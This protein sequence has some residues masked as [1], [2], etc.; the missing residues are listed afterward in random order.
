[1]IR[2]V[3][4]YLETREIESQVSEILA[5]G[6]LTRGPWVD[7]LSRRLESMTGALRAFPTSSATT[8]LYASLRALKIGRGDE[9]LVAD[10]SFPATAN[11]VEECGARPVFVDV[12]PDRWTLDASLLDGLRTERTRAVI[13]VDALGNPSGLASTLE[14]CR[15][16]GLPLIED[17]ACSIGSRVDGRLVGALADLTCFSFHPRKL[18]TSGEGGAILTCDPGLA[19][20]LEVKLAHGGVPSA[21]RFEFIDHG[22][23]FRLP[24]IQCAMLMPQLD[25][26]D[27][28]VER[29][30]RF[31]RE[32]AEGLLPLGFSPQKV[33]PGIIHNVQSL[34]FRVP[35]GS[36]RD[37]LIR[38]LR[39]HGMESTIGTYSMSGTTYFRNRY[40]NPLP[41]SGMLE[42]ETL[43]LPCHDA[44]E[45]AQVVSRVRRAFQEQA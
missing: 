15:R 30:R 16:H 32:V 7:A 10:F 29:R 2:L 11:V 20:T 14:W 45:A 8:A 13:F 41:V 4:P 38:R 35:A 34:A 18:L 22:F 19:E 24:E 42:R 17:A 6:I 44:V 1:M 37:E 40:G 3:R 23:N 31:A 25:Q 33:D 5:T 43:T 9:V 12:D 27:R 21:G 39:E 26:L 28:I 36:S